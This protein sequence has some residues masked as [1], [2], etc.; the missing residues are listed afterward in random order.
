[1]SNMRRGQVTRCSNLAYEQLV[2]H[3]CCSRHRRDPRVRRRENGC[4]R[5]IQSSWCLKGIC[6]A[7]FCSCSDI[8]GLYYQ[9]IVLYCRGKGFSKKHWI[10]RRKSI[11]AS[12]ATNQQT[13]ECKLYCL[14]RSVLRWCLQWE[15]GIML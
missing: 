4:G 10:V 5:R 9:F 7:F 3:S 12:Q 15:L 6:F 1:M 11:F 13:R 14:R 2:H 8:K